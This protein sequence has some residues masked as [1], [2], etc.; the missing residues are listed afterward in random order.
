MRTLSLTELG[1]INGGYNAYIYCIPLLIPILLPK[2]RNPIILLNPRPD[3][4]ENAPIIFP[5]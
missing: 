3:P 4:I 5:K 1:V 2:K